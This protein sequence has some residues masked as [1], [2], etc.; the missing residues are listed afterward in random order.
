MVGSL[1]PTPS[2]ADVAT[3]S[4]LITLG[5]PGGPN[6]SLALP[7][8]PHLCWESPSLRPTPPRCSAC[9]WVMGSVHGAG[10]EPSFREKQI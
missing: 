2:P 6:P 4:A 5:L 1:T 9:S 8:S 10:L 7:R 3:A